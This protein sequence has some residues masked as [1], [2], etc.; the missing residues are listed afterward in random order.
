MAGSFRKA[1]QESIYRRRSLY[2]PFGIPFLSEHR[3]EYTLEMDRIRK[4]RADW[5]EDPNVLTLW[6]FLERDYFDWLM[7]HLVDFI[8]S[9]ENHEKHNR[10]PR[11]K[12]QPLPELLDA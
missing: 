8:F 6:N 10:K 11:N 3:E 9:T 1:H 12:V 2:D 5:E 7:Q 4:A